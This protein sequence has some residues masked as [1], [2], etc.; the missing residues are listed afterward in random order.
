MCVCV[1]EITAVWHNE[2]VFLASFPEKRLIMAVT[3]KG[4]KARRLRQTHSRRLFSIQTVNADKHARNSNRHQQTKPNCYLNNRKWPFHF[5]FDLCSARH[6]NSLKEYQ[7]DINIVIFL[8]DKISFIHKSKL[9]HEK[10]SNI[11]FGHSR[12]NRML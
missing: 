9:Q 3:T 7:G 4:T 5:P 11:Y 10:Y 8:L 12:L 1:L 2:T 6:C